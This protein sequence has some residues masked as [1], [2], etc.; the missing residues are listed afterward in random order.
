MSAEPHRIFDRALLAQHRARAA[1]RC[2]Q[3][4][5][6]ADFL[7]RE[8]ARDFSDRLSMIKRDFAIALDLGTHSG[9]VADAVAD[10][11]NIGMVI[12]ADHCAALLARA[13]GQALACDEE[14]LPFANETL[15][16]VTCPLSLQWVNDLPGTLAQ[17]T[18]ALAPDGLLLAALF[19]P[20]TLRELREALT[21]AEIEFRG[22]ASPRI[23]PF[24][25]L[26]DLGG[27][28]QRA[29]LAL[30]VSDTDRLTV[31]YP[32]M[33][34]LMADLRAMGAANTLVERSRLPLTRAILGRAAEIYAERFSRTDGRVVATFEIITATGWKP[35]DSQQKPLRPGSA[36]AR[37]ADALGTE[38]ISTGEKAQPKRR[39]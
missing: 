2:N 5:F 29:G 8:V 6:S 1:A 32:S 30:P 31:A 15:N 39:R 7:L 12:R 19:G 3:E 26:R 33:F 16:L 37:L 38:E 36:Q 10:L 4:G 20:D 13:L 23:A 27:L 9:A 21:E 34:E 24:I 11:G 18:R 35:H 14:W 17:I 25:E 22:G 28:L